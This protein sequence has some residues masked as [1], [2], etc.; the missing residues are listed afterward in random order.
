MDMPQTAVHITVNLADHHFGFSEQVDVV[1]S[2][3]LRSDN[4]LDNKTTGERLL[5][6]HWYRDDLTDSADLPCRI[7]ANRN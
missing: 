2:D 6:W 7:P 3:S 4:C 5:F 1:G